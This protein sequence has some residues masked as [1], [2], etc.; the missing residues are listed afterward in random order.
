MDKNQ[1]A[2]G[3]KDRGVIVT[4]ASA[5]IGLA[6]SRALAEEG[7]R[8]A[9]WDLVSQR[10]GLGIPSYW[11]TRVDVTDE[12]Q[13]AEAVRATTREL[14]P[15]DAL[16]HSAGILRHGSVIT[17]S[18]SDW[19]EVIGVNLTG[20]FLVLRAVCRQLVQQGG[21]GNIVVLGSTAGIRAPLDNAAYATAKAGLNMLVQTIARDLGPHGVRINTVN[22]GPV[23]SEM[24]TE[25]LARFADP[26][27]A[28]E[29]LK[30]EVPLGRLADIN[31]V[32]RLVVFLLSN[33]SSYMT[34]C[35]VQ[36]DGGRTL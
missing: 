11:S 29:R 7:A 36:I 32:V 34:G 1:I 24:M 10:V 26:A 4:G 13:V 22:P 21:R 28:L 12:D 23:D 5:G 9:A 15:I 16:V 17:T 33:A 25:D 30:T 35:S 31:D 27:E 8:V 19:N 14:G 2:G 6:V 3:L 20:S 18:T